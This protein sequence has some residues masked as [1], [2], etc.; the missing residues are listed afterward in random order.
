MVKID[1]VS[2]AYEGL[3][4][5]GVDITLDDV[6]AAVIHLDEV[7]VGLGIGKRTLRF[8]G[9]VVSAIGP[10]TL[11]VRQL[12]AY[13]ERRALTEV[14]KPG[15]QHGTRTVDGFTVRWRN[16]EES[17]TET[18]DAR[19]VAVALNDNGIVITAASASARAETSRIELRHGQVELARGNRSVPRISGL[20]ADSLMANVSIPAPQPDLAS[21]PATASALSEPSSQ[22]DA[23]AAG[24]LAAT[25]SKAARTAD[26]LM[27]PDAAVHLDSVSGHFQR[28]AD[29]LNLGPGTLIVQRADHRL[30]VKGLVPERA[31]SPTGPG[32]GTS[33]S[34]PT[35]GTAPPSNP[36]SEEA[37]TFRLSLP[38]SDEPGE[39]VADLT[40]G[41]IWLSTLGIRDGDFGLFDVGQTSLSTRAHIV[42]AANG[43]TVH[44][45]GEGKV[46]GLSL[47]SRAL[48]DEPVAGLELA[49]R[50]RSDIDL[51][52][53]H[54]RIDDGE[55]DLGAIHL[56]LRGEVTRSPAKPVAVRPSSRAADGG[57]VA[58]P[59][60]RVK[61]ST[62]EPIPRRSTATP[63]PSLPFQLT[64]S[65]TGSLARSAFP[66]PA[67]NPCLTPLRAG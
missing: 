36:P 67:V 60:L 8:H 12:E 49:V 23:N 24:A 58:D 21:S 64:R 40:G 3:R 22:P 48:S 27:A 41:P 51:N 66:L 13:R 59:V 25:L 17:A 39:V 9:G 1:R 32:A 35:H 6:P 30:I 63:T 53:E 50:G 28:G 20:H 52:G 57:R 19:E 5:R 18:L 31:P 47:R 29:S 26:L 46:H 44:V 34:V 38:L 11:L 15:S 14:A 45:E 42:L 56:A 2:P 4:L 7:D 65:V 16:A 55:V 10:S 61:S 54:V 43:K 33:A 62:F 37:L